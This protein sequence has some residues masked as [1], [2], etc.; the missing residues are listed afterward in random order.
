VFSRLLNAAS[1]ARSAA[2]GIIE[3]SRST[4]FPT[5]IARTAGFLQQISLFLDE[6][7]QACSSVHLD[8]EDID[9]VLGVQDS[10]VKLF[11]ALDSDAGQDPNYQHKLCGCR[12]HLDDAVAAL[13]TRIQAEWAPAA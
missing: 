6:T 11:L 7:A 9:C 3:E 12:A 13:R 5:Q 1:I 8:R 2:E 10:L 4:R